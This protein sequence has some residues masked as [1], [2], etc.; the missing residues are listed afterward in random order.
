M[1]AHPVPSVPSISLGTVFMVISSKERGQHPWEPSGVKGR[2]RAQ[3]EGAGPG[4]PRARVGA[5]C[6]RWV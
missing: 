5:R 6:G 2:H 3:K 1:M 4:G